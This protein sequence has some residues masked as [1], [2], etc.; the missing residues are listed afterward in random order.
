MILYCNN[1]CLAG[2]REGKDHEAQHGVGA[3]FD[4]WNE[5]ED[6]V[7]GLDL[8]LKAAMECFVATRKA[9]KITFTKFRFSVERPGEIEGKPCRV[10]FGER[11]R[12]SRPY[13]QTD[14]AHVYPIFFNELG[15]FNRW[16]A[17]LR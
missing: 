13:S 9:G 1:C 10:F 6:H 7:A 12:F 4:L 14:A 2:G 5:P 17:I 8:N 3:F 11:I 15:R 16:K